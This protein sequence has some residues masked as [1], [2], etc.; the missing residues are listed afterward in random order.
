[1]TLVDSVGSS[2]GS[3]SKTSKLF[4][5]PGRLFAV[6]GSDEE[7]YDSFNGVSGFVVFSRIDL[8][9]V[10]LRTVG[11]AGCWKLHVL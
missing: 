11:R 6:V 2:R 5:R 9:S 10:L 3:D 1:M 4:L 8:F 7:R